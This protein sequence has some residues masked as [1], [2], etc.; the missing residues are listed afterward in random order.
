M[1]F[2]STEMHLPK[3]VKYAPLSMIILLKFSMKKY[4]SYDIRFSGLELGC[5]YTDFYRVH[6][7]IDVS[8]L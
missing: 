1:Y 3:Y 4:F 2:T 6:S 7:R 5:V 8:P